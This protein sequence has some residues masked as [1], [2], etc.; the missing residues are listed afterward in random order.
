MYESWPFFGSIM[1]NVQAGLCKGDMPIASLYAGLTDEPVRE[2]IFG[3]ILQEYELTKRMVL[4][5]TDLKELLENESWLQRSI[6]LRNP[7]V[8][9]MNY[10][11]VALLERLRA[12]PDSEY[13][14]Q[15]RDTLLLSVNGVAAGLQNTG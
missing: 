1:D 7:Y 8:D 11:Q 10:I 13:A 5:V 14:T 3:D 9:P 4:D 15:M 2:S 6:K 12:Q